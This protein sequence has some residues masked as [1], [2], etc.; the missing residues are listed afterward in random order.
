MLDSGRVDSIARLRGLLDAHR[1]AGPEAAAALG[2]PVGSEHR[3]RA[4]R[5]LYLRR[6]AETKP[7]HTLIKLFALQAGVPEAEAR[8]AFD[9]LPI[10][11]VVAL[12]LVERAGDRV[13]PLVGLLVVEGLV[14]ARDRPEEG[15]L[16]VQ[17]DHVLGV[18]PPALLLAR[19]TVRRRVRR[20][21]DLGCGSGVQALLAARHAESVVGVDLNPRALAFARFNARLNGVS[22][23]EWREG[24]LFAPVAGERFDLVVANP[25][26]VVSPE[27]WLLFRDGGGGG[28]GICER[29]VA[30]L[31]EHLEEG[32]FATVLANWPLRE[33]EHWSE[34]PRRWVEG[35]GCDAWL[36][37]SDT[38]DGL[39]YA[40][41]WTRGPDPEGYAEAI[42]R[43]TAHYAA[44]GIRSLAMGALVLR[45]RTAS[46]NW[47][48]ADELPATPDG[49][50]SGALLRVFAG[51]DRLRELGEDAELLDEVFRVA[52]PVRLQQTVAF[53]GGAPEVRGAE[54]G[55]VDG[56]PLR[57]GADGGTIRLVQLC[58]GRRPLREVVAE[59]ARS[60]GSDASEVAERTLA[61][62]RRLVGLGFLVPAGR[63]GEGRP[64]DGRRDEVVAE[65]DVAATGVGGAHRRPGS[66]GRGPEGRG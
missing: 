33:G 8:A 20:V 3:P 10:D 49:E 14:L 53:V 31:G 66:G 64:G 7:L 19:L 30:G 52:E 35:T 39:T 55:L 63:A 45:R 56:L 51:E 15:T 22:N 25:P 2:V 48:R 13:R 23:V 57:G 40:A 27:S 44:L 18:N 4:D 50:C 61:V 34:R 11:E 6:L 1:F 12:G 28:D 46:S 58:D 38:Q 17:P 9:P 62:V 36:L 41:V 16:T 29:V 47:V 24:D 59:M 37:H 32:G 65:T 54:L 60:G 43:W 21:L 42:D 5:P 26:Y